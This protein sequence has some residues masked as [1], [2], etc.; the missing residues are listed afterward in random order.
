MIKKLIY[1]FL[2]YFKFQI[3]DLVVK[4]L[5]SLLISLFILFSFH[6]PLDDSFPAVI[7]YS[8]SLPTLGFPLSLP[9]FIPFYVPLQ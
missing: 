6:C 4:V 3:V 7:F 2:L 8:L 9:L 5:C 1:F